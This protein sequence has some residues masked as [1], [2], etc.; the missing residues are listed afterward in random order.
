MLHRVLVFAAVL[1]LALGAVR[2][3]RADDAVECDRM[4]DACDAQILELCPAGADVLDEQEVPGPSPQV[5]R[6]RIIFRCRGAAAAPAPVAAPA[7]APAPAA[8][9]AATPPP[10]PA[11]P[12]A[13]EEL[14]TV[15]FRLSALEAEK[16]Q[17]GIVGP[18]V[19]AGSGLLTT[20]LF[21]GI[22]LNAKSEADGIEK[23]G[24]KDTDSD[25]DIDDDDLTED[26]FRA[27]AKVSGGLAGLGGALMAGGGVWLW[28]RLKKRNANKD[29][30]EELE[31]RR[32]ELSRFGLSVDP[33]ART[34]ALRASF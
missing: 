20:A 3:A 22:A 10:A 32:R 5:R 1:W 24:A 7:P 26:E 25:G 34:F 30:I 28:L 21:M 23:F 27:T 33:I 8:E 4:R 2:S 31:A 18:I 9:S 19:L 15:N 17:H 6:Y 16:R 14:A 29:E 11:D 12:A 13:Q